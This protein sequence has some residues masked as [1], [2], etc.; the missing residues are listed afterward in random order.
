MHHIAGLLI[1]PMYTIH[2]HIKYMHTELIK[3]C[4]WYMHMYFSDVHVHICTSI[5]WGTIFPTLRLDH[6][7][8]LH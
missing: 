8:S 6:V 3:Q 5:P 4:R 7:R 1:T 2:I